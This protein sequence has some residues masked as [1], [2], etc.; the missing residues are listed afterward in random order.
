LSSKEF[1]KFTKTA[2]PYLNLT[3]HIEGRPEDAIAKEHG[4]RGFPTLMFLDA[5][6]KEVGKPSSRSV[7]GFDSTLSD[8]KALDVIREKIK[9]GVPGLE[10]PLLLREM[11]MDA[12]SFEDAAKS[13]KRL[14]KPK[15]MKAKAW[16][17]M[18]AEIDGKMVNLEVGDLIQNAGRDKE[19]NEA[20]GKIFYAMAK[21]G[22]SVSGRIVFPF[23]RGA[24]DV[25]REK[26][27]AVVFEAGLKA[28]EAE[29]GSNPRARAD[30]DKWKA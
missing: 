25:A 23:W 27:D 4:V 30:L 24:M 12:I 3:N 17:E 16:K 8:I 21:D 22:K 5:S 10:A 19:K 20:L 6:G 13:R 11:N 14:T 2:I 29:F 1:P 28:L 18:L 9:K 7:E 15:K 26:K